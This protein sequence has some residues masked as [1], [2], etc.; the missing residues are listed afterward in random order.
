MRTCNLLILPTLACFALA[1][2]IP[3]VD[4]AAGQADAFKSYEPFS[5]FAPTDVTSVNRIKGIVA[6]QNEPLN[7]DKRTV[8]VTYRV[9][10][11]RIKT[12]YGDA[13]STKVQIVGNWSIGLEA[14]EATLGAANPMVTGFESSKGVGQPFVTVK[15]PKT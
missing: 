11:D 13:T 2:A 6:M 4:D 3:A 7:R 9:V 8:I 15:P 12:T 10:E 14:Q 1:S 5:V